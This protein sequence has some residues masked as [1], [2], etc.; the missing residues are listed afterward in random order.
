MTGTFFDVAKLLDDSYSPLRGRT[1]GFNQVVNITPADLWHD[2]LRRHV[3]SLPEAIPASL[4]VGVER[5]EGRPIFL[6][7]RLLLTV[8]DDL[9]ESKPHTSESEW[10]SDIQAIKDP[11]ARRLA[12]FLYSR[13]DFAWESSVATMVERI[14]KFVAPT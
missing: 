4:K 12:G 11:S 7:D 13:L 5:L 2:L 10:P 9:V 1:K 3:P 8:L 14:E 6:F